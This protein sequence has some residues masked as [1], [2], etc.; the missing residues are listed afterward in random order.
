LPRIDPSA[1]SIQRVFS[2]TETPSA[3]PRGIVTMSWM[4][5]LC[6]SRADVANWPA[7]GRAQQAMAVAANVTANVAAIANGARRA[8]RVGALSRRSLPKSH[9]PAVWFLL[10]PEVS[11]IRPNTAGIY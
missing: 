2:A 10:A 5:W 7:D 1:K 9:L 6:V 11:A 3:H 8:D 4:T